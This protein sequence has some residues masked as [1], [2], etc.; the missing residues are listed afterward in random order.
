MHS[1]SW[2]RLTV[3]S[4]GDLGALK[5]VVNT[6]EAGLCPVEHEAGTPPQCYGSQ[7]ATLRV[8]SYLEHKNLVMAQDGYD[9]KVYTIVIGQGHCGGVGET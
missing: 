7:G 1:S 4:G 3:N 8:P 6:R 2:E 5:H 9:G